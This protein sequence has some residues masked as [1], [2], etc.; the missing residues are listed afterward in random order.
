MKFSSIESIALQS[1]ASISARSYVTNYLSRVF[2][3]VVQRKEKIGLSRLI[4]HD[5]N[6]RP[7][8]AWMMTKYLTGNRVD[9]YQNP[10]YS[11]DLSLCDFLL[12]RK[13]KNQLLGIHFNID[14]EVL[15]VL[16]YAIRCLTKEDFQNCFIDWFCRKQKCVAVGE[17]YFAK[18]H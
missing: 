4:L 9:S 13:L 8:R 3:A 17:E 2:D 5:D 11:P 15:K 6:A 18:I 7:H 16:D 14:E 1:G 12:F 10:P